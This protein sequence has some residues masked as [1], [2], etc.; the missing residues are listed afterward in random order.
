MIPVSLAAPIAQMVFNSHPNCASYETTEV[1][2]R[3]V[4]KTP[5][6]AVSRM[7]QIA[8]KTAGTKILFLPMM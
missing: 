5:R 7:V 3:M 6:H 1:I 2:V 8:Q 4:A